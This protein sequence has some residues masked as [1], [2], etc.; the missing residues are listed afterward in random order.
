MGLSALMVHY[1]NTWPAGTNVS[2]DPQLIKVKSEIRNM[3]KDFYL[4]KEFYLRGKGFYLVV[5]DQNQTKPTIR[6]QYY[7]IL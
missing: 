3:Q 4:K 2:S 6:S 5:L 1:C 7:T